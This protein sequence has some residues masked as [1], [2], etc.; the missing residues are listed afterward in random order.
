MEVLPGMTE[1]DN[2]DWVHLAATIDTWG[3]RGTTWVAPE[4]KELTQIVPLNM[5]G[6]ARITFNNKKEQH[7]SESDIEDASE[8]SDQCTSYTESQEETDSELEETKNNPSLGM[9]HSRPSTTAY[10][11]GL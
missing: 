2:V 7:L 10:D 3:T 9:R 4:G 1:S 6:V 5:L 11:R 8:D